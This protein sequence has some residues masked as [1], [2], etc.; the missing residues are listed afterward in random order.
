M[1][2]CMNLSVVP[3]RAGYTRHASHTPVLRHMRT[4]IRLFALQAASRAGLAASAAAPPLPTSHAAPAK[5]LVEHTTAGVVQQA[6]VLGAQG[7]AYTVPTS[8]AAPT[9]AGG[10]AAAP[11][12]RP[13]DQPGALVPGAE[14]GSVSEASAQTATCALTPP[15][16]HVQTLSCGP[17]QG[18]RQAGQAPGNHA[19]GQLEAG[20]PSAGA[21]TY[22]GLDASG[23]QAPRAPGSSGA[24]CPACA[25]V[26]ANRS[27]PG[28]LAGERGSHQA[29]RCA[30]EAS[31]PQG[32]PATP[33]SGPASPWSQR[34]GAA[35]PHAGCAEAVPAARS[36]ERRAHECE[37]RRRAAQRTCSEEARALRA[38]GRLS[39]IVMGRVS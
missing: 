14:R 26:R 28:S 21:L 16:Q 33:C 19:D 4:I 27:G 25:P 6:D 10:G 30:A 24:A 5:A 29:H 11:S 18:V 1:H 9:A 17:D 31:R 35:L 36:P 38:E 8:S 34:R 13:P 39:D 3:G 32:P 20:A 12:A 23:A 2:A 22:H 15:P 37:W 7:A